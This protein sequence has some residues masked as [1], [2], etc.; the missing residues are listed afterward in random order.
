[1]N[2]AEDRAENIRLLRDSAAAVV[3]PGDMK[4]IRVLRFREPGFDRATWQAMCDMG[5]AGLRVPEAA[6]GSGLG[7]QEYCALAEELGAGLV[8][9]PLIPCAMSARLL[10]GDALAGLLS[11]ERVIIPAWQECANTLDAQ[12]DTTVAG[13]R[14]SGRKMFVPMAAGADAFLVSG[15][16][17][18]ALVDRAAPGLRL[19]IER[20][21][22]G[23]NFGTLSL[24]D[25]HCT[26]VAGDMAAAI[27]EAALATAAYLLGVMDRAFAITLDYLRTR[28]QF[29]R[30]I[31]SFQS[32]QHRAADLKIQVA[33]TRASVDSAA[34][35]LD[36][37]A[38]PAL[39]QAAVSR[40]K[41][42]AADASMLVTRQAIQLHG[43]IGYTDEY[44]V[45]LFLR[46]AMVLANLYGS[47]ALHRR[48]YAAAAPDQ[49]DE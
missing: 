4:R 7:M 6:G 38:A 32:L 47:A 16:D 22:D 9:E 2:A 28:Q 3:A 41:A 36:S 44:D 12:G 24:A 11:G 43:G 49:D 39:R 13:G 15:R 46:K 40:A 34:A 48:R 10:A 20:T 42:R 19:T 29:G 27:E 26:P 21:Q 31:G 14:A 5:W 37:A 45:G 18:L 23:G 8:P 30:P 33:L 35:T 25:A 1:M 17:G